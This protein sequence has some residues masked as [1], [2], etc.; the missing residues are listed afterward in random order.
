MLPIVDN[1]LT[2]IAGGCLLLYLF[3]I[4]SV[5]FIVYADNILPR[6]RTANFERGITRKR[7]SHFSPPG[8]LRRGK[9]VASNLGSLLKGLSLNLVEHPEVVDAPG[10]RAKY[11]SNDFVDAIELAAAMLML[12]PDNEEVALLLARTLDR[13]GDYESSIIVWNHLVEGGFNGQEAVVRLTRLLYSNRR[14]RRCSTLCDTMIENGWD[15]ELALKIKARITNM[16]GDEETSLMLWKRISVINP[17]DTEANITLDR[18]L[19]STKRFD[20][21]LLNI[22]R[23]LDS[24]PEDLNDL[25]F[26]V[27]V[28]VHL[29]DN[30][31]VR[32]VLRDIASIA[33]EDTD[34]LYTIARFAYNADDMPECI[35]ALNKLLEIDVE[36][37]DGLNLLAR[38]LTNDENY[39]E[40]IIVRKRISLITPKDI[41]NLYT[42]ARL[43]YNSDDIPECIDAL[44]KLLEIDVEHLNGLNLLARALTKD[45]NEEAGILVR[46][47]ISSITPEDIDNLYTIARLSYNSDDIPECIDALTKLLKIDVNHSDGTNLLI[48]ALIKKGDESKA[49]DMLNKLT[50]T[51][52][53]N[54]QMALQHARLAYR[55]EDYVLS[56]GIFQSLWEKTGSDVPA[57]GM[58]ASM[59]NIPDW[60]AALEFIQML[61]NESRCSELRAERMCRI[62][63]NMKRYSKVTEFI[64]S[65]EEQYQSNSTIL[66][67]GGRALMSEGTFEEARGYWAKLIEK[68]SEML[69]AH[70]GIARCS[71]NLREDDVAA[72]QIEAVLLRD[73]D[74]VEALAIKAQIFVRKEMWKEALALSNELS[75][76]NPEDH[77]FWRRSIEILYRLNLK[78]EAKTM[79]EEA[80]DTVP[81]TT[82][83]LLSLIFL[84]E[85][86]LWEEKAQVLVVDVLELS[87]DKIDTL[88]QLITGYYNYGKVNMAAR[89]AQMLKE[90]DG[91]AF[92]D[93]PH[94]AKMLELLKWASMELDDFTENDDEHTYSIELVAKAIVE[95]TVGER[96]E[97]SPIKNVSM[98]TSTLGKGGAERQLVFCIRCLLDDPEQDFNVELYANIHNT[99]D[100]ENTYYEHIIDTPISLFEYVSPRNWNILHHPNAQALEKWAPL[101]EH[102][103][104]E[105]RVT[106]ARL[107]YHFID[108]KPD[109]VHAWQDVTNVLTG[110]AALMAGVPRILF[111]ARSLSPDTKT[112]LHMRKA[113][114][115]RGSYN[116]LL[117]AE[118][119]ILCHNSEAGADSYRDWLS[120]DKFTLP[121][122]HNG[123]A[124]EDLD[125]LIDGDEQARMNEFMKMARDS[126]IVGAVFRF[127]PEKR[128][129]LWINVAAE[130][131]NHKKNIIFLLVGDGPMFDQ[132]QS[133]AKR[134][135]ISDSVFFAG[136]SNSVGVW[137]RLMDMFLLTSSIEGLPNVIIEA[138]G[139]G[140]PVISTDVGGAKEVIIPGL[141]GHVVEDD[142]VE[143]IAKTVLETLEHEKW[144]LNASKMSLQHARTNFS[145]EGMYDRL[146]KL[147]DSIQ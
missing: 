119:V 33:P 22:N 40:G 24:N 91:N 50:S 15:E 19:F 141:T 72:R 143:V 147:Y 35:D 21:L 16:E 123:T 29:K 116:H 80:I 111:S 100:R 145:V 82:S 39:E 45:G 113:G 28:L 20:E 88:N 137:L 68:D 122:L 36:H 37:L 18:L 11:N 102:M 63:Y 27:K 128:P 131:L 58:I 6:I 3:L 8:K 74:H 120:T 66:V 138:Q 76:K 34:N 84:A 13:I 23:R 117:K 146:L 115:L 90:E 126:L 114:Y 96:G 101:L 142:S 57:D 59:M 71:Y 94:I 127:V 139:F 51:G 26:K 55:T 132:S 109:L 43:S 67:L 87:S 42:I 5:C 108:R 107:F 25:R 1:L 112:M 65:L 97:I 32:I 75:K 118:R 12:E 78:E 48:R 46:N 38:A 89:F 134:L 62:L 99:D 93:S 53:L 92:Q 130:I 73:K 17:E 81:K 105:R 7:M 54:E 144:R 79:F 124:F 41:D 85:E 49:L 133:E 14:W 129:L 2:W 86:Y 52:K 64:D 30:T 121:I 110:M 69:E 103:P 44:T 106:V 56:K 9:H 77:R 31:E 98:V 47:R 136:Q 61:W 83:G 140:V 135:G 4:G 104:E 125:S 70:M 95:R 60:E 10:I